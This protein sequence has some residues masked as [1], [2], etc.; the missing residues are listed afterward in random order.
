[1]NRK[2]AQ[3]FLALI[4]P[5]NLS[6]TMTTQGSFTSVRILSASRTMRT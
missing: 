3:L 6:C 2:V 1:M 5:K 4:T